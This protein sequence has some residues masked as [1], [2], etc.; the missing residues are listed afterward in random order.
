MIT[1]YLFTCGRKT[2]INFLLLT[3]FLLQGQAFAIETDYKGY[4]GKNGCASIIFSSRRSNCASLSSK[5]DEACKRT[6]IKCNYKKAKSIVEKYKKAK[7]QLKRAKSAKDKKA[8]DEAEAK[9]SAFKSD[10]DSRKQ[11]G[12]DG[13]PKA[14]RCVDL[15]KEVQVVFERTIP[16]L[17]QAKR[18][19]YDRKDKMLARLKKAK[20]IRKKFKDEK[21]KANK[22]KDG[23]VKRAAKEKWEKARKVV[24]LIENNLKKFNERKI[25][26]SVHSLI[27]QYRAGKRSHSKELANNYKKL[28]NCKKL[29]SI[30]Y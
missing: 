8:E 10:L 16:L 27:K 7:D 26:E 19:E 18:K 2:A 25:K 9:I 21:D 11:Q 15:R 13:I 22:G 24:A 28:S 29:G 12:K 30:S 23:N 1:K 4:A 14:K 17:E 5:M 20:D 6:E 3:A